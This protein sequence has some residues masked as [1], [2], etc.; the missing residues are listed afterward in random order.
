MDF[1]AYPLYLNIPSELNASVSLP[2]EIIYSKYRL[3]IIAIGIL[4]A[5][6]LYF[7]F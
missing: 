3:L 1:G 2:L 6:F 4:I 7:N 5:F